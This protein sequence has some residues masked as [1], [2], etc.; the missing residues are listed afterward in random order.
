MLIILVTSSCDFSSCLACVV[1]SRKR[2]VCLTNNAL[3]CSVLHILQEDR[4]KDAL[5]PKSLRFYKDMSIWI[6]MTL[7][8]RDQRINQL[9]IAT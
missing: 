4:G 5:L 1:L 8:A 3:F 6:P 7:K 9:K 2:A